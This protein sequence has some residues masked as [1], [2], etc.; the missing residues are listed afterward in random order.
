MAEIRGFLKYKR[1]KTG[2]RPIEQRICDYREVELTLTPEDI[3]Q[4]AARC[5]DCG[6]P[7]CHGMGCPLGNNIP[8]FNDY[9]YKGQWQQACDVLHSTNNFPEITGRIC[10][11]PCETAC[12]LA[13]NDEPVFIR[14]IEYQIV[15]RG[16]K[17][18]WI[19]PV[20]AQQKTGKRIAVI[21]S[22]PAG[23]AAAQQLAR[24]GHNVVVFEKDDKIGGL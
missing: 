21:G 5:I 14:H 13:V 8:E 7:F 11:A 10:P 20:I 22:G 3:I 17:E 18:G 15:E 24:A 6:I 19:K 2:Y 1:K 23:L 16:F 12:T 9:V 4:Q